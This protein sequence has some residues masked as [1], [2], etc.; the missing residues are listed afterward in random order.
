MYSREIKSWINKEIT[1]EFP[2]LP[3]QFQFLE[4]IDI[5]IQDPVNRQ[6]KKKVTGHNSELLDM[7][8]ASQ[9]AHRD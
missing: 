9:Q 5:T 4:D 7:V 6:L 8:R 3:G 2:C 1:V